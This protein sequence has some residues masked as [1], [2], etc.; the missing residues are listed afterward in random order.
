MEIFNMVAKENQMRCFAYSGH[1][2]YKPNKS[3]ASGYGSD[4]W[5]YLCEENGRNY[6]LVF[7]DDAS[8]GTGWMCVELL[9]GDSEKLINADVSLWLDIVL[10]RNSTCGIRWRMLTACDICCPQVPAAAS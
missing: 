8:Y 2:R 9:E 5:M 6:I 1:T 4:E 10:S 3:S 7:S